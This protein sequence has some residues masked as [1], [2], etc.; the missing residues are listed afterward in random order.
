VSKATILAGLNGLPALPVTTPADQL[1][2]R[3][4]LAGVIQDGIDAGHGGGAVPETRKINTSSP[5]TGGGDLSADRTLAMPAATVA[6]DG[7]ATAAQ[8]TAIGTAQATANAAIPKSLATAADQGLY[9]TGIGAWAVS[10]LTSFGR[11]LWAVVDAAAFKLLVTYSKSDVGLGNVDNTSDVGKPVSTAQ[12]TADG[13]R[14][15][16]AGDTLT[17]TL[18][19]TGA[20]SYVGIGTAAPVAPLD[21]RNVVAYR[22][23]NTCQLQV[24]TAPG[25]VQE[26]GSLGAAD[27]TALT[28]Y[29]GKFNIYKRNVLGNFVPSDL[30]WTL[31][32]SGNVIVERGDET[33]GLVKILRT[34]TIGIGTVTPQAPLDVRGAVAY[35]G[36]N[37]TQLQVGIAP[38]IMQ[39][40]G[41]L[42][43][44]DFMVFSTYSG[45]FLIY[46]GNHAGSLV[47]ADL[48]MTVDSSGHMQLGGASGL[49]YTIASTAIL[50]LPAGS[51]TAG[52]APIKLTSG[53][54]L[55][56]AEAGAVE[57]D[58]TSFFGSTTYRSA[59][60]RGVKVDASLTPGAV[61]A[62]S[63]L[64]ETYAVTG[65]I[66]PH[67]VTV[68]PPSLNSGLGIMWAR[69]STTDTLEI[70]WRNFTAGSLTPAAGT[71]RVAG[72]RV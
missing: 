1:A 42:G 27:A 60:V 24:N 63:V 57:F 28:T 36:V 7:Y 54:L 37:M 39:E 64:V 58:G 2:V 62:N 10:T 14:V 55:T 35:R 9:S 50:Q 69:C 30:A 45:K 72:V 71:Y 11:S 22:G 33:V 13:L 26:N 65:L 12:A 21:I 41:A 48:K 43:A 66:V 47:N 52:T 32:S 17:G 40:N 4:A 3:D 46:K 8:I 25:L 70:C 56:A 67:A 16:K 18:G 38:A 19:M 51:A 23:T 61:A 15:L 59:F 44:S 53:T 49:D 6:S 5:L 34:G 20:T 31:D 68:S 29:L